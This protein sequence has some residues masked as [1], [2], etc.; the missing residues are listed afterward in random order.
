[1]HGAGGLDELS[2]LGPSQVAELKD[3][4]VTR[5]QL[6]PEDLGLPRAKLEDLL[7]GDGPE[8]AVALRAVLDGR[9]G[10]FRD[11]A[12][13]TSAAALLIAGKAADLKQGLALATQ[14]LDAG[15][16]RE[17]LDAL[18]RLTNETVEAPA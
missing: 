3:G 4:K 14:A 16:A 9:K 12:L 15:K 2:T 7:G 11:I 5:F 1:V 13:L 18:V 6:A 8:N 10:A 17:K